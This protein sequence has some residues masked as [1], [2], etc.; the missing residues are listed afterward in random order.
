MSIDVIAA[1]CNQ[2]IRVTIGDITILE[3]AAIVNAAN[4]SL[5][6]GG[7]VDGAIHRAAGPALLA[8]CKKI[9]AESF[10]LGLATGKAVITGAGILPA[11]FV[12]HTVGPIW[13]ELKKAELDSLLADCYN[14]S[15]TIT[16]QN[17]IRSV[18]FPAISTGIYGYPKERAA[19][20][21]YLTVKHYLALHPLPET[22]YF[23]F[24]STNDSSIF[25][26]CV[27]KI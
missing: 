3:V 8:E 23:V 13:N 21:A 25:L 6:G 16:T 7:G 15:L 17:K 5:M 14:N 22:V 1:F 11:R 12:I 10:P 2:R 9:R 18:A 20:I 27:N 24:F 26:D 19:R 4:S